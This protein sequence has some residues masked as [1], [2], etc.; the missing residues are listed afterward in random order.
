MNKKIFTLTCFVVFALCLVLTAC[1]TASSMAQT[2]IANVVTAIPAASNIAV[3]KTPIQNGK[4]AQP[5]ALGAAVAQTSVAGVST[6]QPAGSAESL[7]QTAVAD[8]STAMPAG[9]A[10]I[11][12]TA[13]AQIFNA[14]PSA[15]ASTSSNRP[16]SVAI[17]TIPLFPGL[18]QLNANDSKAIMWLNTANQ[19]AEKTGYQFDGKAYVTSATIDNI[20][21]FYNNALKGWKATPPSTSSFP[22]LG[23]FTIWIYSQTSQNE[24]LTLVYTPYDAAANKFLLITELVWQ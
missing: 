15:Q 8:V 23:N 9:S 2:A 24:T 7:A 1:G 20:S 18:Q 3:T 4:S 17:P 19:M 11:A 12:Q 13:I 14:L 10:A 16:T 5:S 21:T 22:T 6:S